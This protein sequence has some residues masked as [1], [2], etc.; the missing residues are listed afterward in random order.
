MIFATAQYLIITALVLLS[1]WI[2]LRNYFPQ[3]CDSLLQ[4]LRGA[5][6]RY[7]HIRFIGWLATRLEQSKAISS[8]CG[9]CQSCQACSPAVPSEFHEPDVIRFVDP[10][11]Q[12]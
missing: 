9:S 11:I 4:N 12:K 2:T 5:C 8:S 1:L 7:R 3:I 10:D 6:L